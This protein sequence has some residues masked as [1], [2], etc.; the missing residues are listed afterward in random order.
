VPAVTLRTT[1]AAGCLDVSGRDRIE[2]L[3]TDDHQG[4]LVPLIRRREEDDP[5]ALRRTAQVVPRS[6]R[7]SCCELRADGNIVGELPGP[8]AAE[9]HNGLLALATLEP[10]YLVEVPLQLEW[11][12]RTDA[13][14]VGVTALVDL[15]RL[16]LLAC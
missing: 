15:R 14:R 8:L 6:D 9:V 10:P 1:D 3:A 16:R 5:G 13:T 11:R 12:E 4:E 2:V 7:I